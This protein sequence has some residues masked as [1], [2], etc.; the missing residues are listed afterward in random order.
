MTWLKVN[1]VL[2][3]FT[4]EQGGIEYAEQQMQSIACKCM[5]YID[6]HVKEKAIKDA[7]TAYL[8]YVIQRKY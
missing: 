1:A 4:K 8:N 2:V 5:D 6:Y 3:E 7:L